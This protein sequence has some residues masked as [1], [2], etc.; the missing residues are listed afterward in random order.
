[1]SGRRLPGRRFGASASLAVAVLA[2]AAVW[3]PA[4][5]AENVVT[6]HVLVAPITIDVS[7]PAPPAPVGK[8]VKIRAEVDNV[9]TASLDG[10][11]LTLRLDGGALLVRR[12]PEIVLKALRPGKQAKA[13]WAVCPLRSGS[14]VVLVQASVN[15]FVLESPARLL[16]VSEGK[17]DKSCKAGWHFP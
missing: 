10:I 6:G 14:Y 8:D 15:D 5:A 11:T 7:I 16:I 2:A 1:M 9:G 12:S 4:A 17:H 3:V 13:A